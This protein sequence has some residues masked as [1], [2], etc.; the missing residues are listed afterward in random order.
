MRRICIVFFQSS[1]FVFLTFLLLTFLLLA[2]LFTP[3]SAW[4]QEDGTAASIAEKDS[5]GEL[6][7][8]RDNCPIKHVI[9]CAEVLFTG[10]PVHIAVGTIAPQ[11]GVG[12][13]VAYL[14]HK[15]TDNWRINWNSD[16]VASS[17]ASWRAGLYVKFVDSRQ[18]DMVAERGTKGAGSNPT[19]LPEQPVINL[20]AQTTSLNKLTYFGLGSNT[21]VTGRS[22]YGM[23]ESLVGAS[24]VKPFHPA[25]HA[26]IYGELSG[27]WTDVRGSRQQESPSI[28]QL[29]T[30]AT[31]PGLRSQP[32]FLQ[33]GAGLR[34]RPS[35][36]DDLIHLNYDAAYR[37]YMAVSDHHASFQRFTIDLSHQV[38]LYRKTRLLL[39][40]ETNGP[41]DCSLDPTADRPQC[42]R[43]TTTTRNLE[44][45]VGIRV[46]TALSMTP[47]AATVPFYLQPTIG[48][49]DINGNASLGSYADYRFRAPNL[50]VLRE[51]FEH[52]VW[53]WPVGFMLLAD[54]GQLALTR[55][56]LGS[57]PWRHSFSTGLTLRA[58]G[59]PQV[60]LLFS[61]GGNE[62]THINANVNSSLLGASTRPSLF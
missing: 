9:G 13:G 52:S 40:R 4:S 57:N 28:E 3:G 33:L 15:T 6:G 31:A 2:F 17:N 30:D 21:P 59:F 23:T 50:L 1:I 35:F 10:Q 24:G 42:P 25:L 7:K 36:K 12:A 16:A 55:G 26:S 37:P 49:S 19:E 51:S 60:D 32:F 53:K 27:R 39:P 22:F 5:P 56:D 18:P 41:D 48:G 58:G 43:A 45:S 61:W 8:L 54:Q 62:G 34:A 47:G 46:F 20:Y 11:N 44:G 29:Y 38:S 14:G